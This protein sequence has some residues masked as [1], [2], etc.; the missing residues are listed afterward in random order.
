MKRSIMLPKFSFGREVMK[1]VWVYVMLAGGTGFVAALLSGVDEWDDKGIS[2][3]VV[4]R[5]V[6]SGLFAILC[7]IGFLKAKKLGEEE[8]RIK[9]EKDKRDLNI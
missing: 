2:I 1:M 8:D 5:L 3:S 7:L 4:I 6:I 9:S